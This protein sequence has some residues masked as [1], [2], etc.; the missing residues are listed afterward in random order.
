M[1]RK[2]RIPSKG[3]Q[4]TGHQLWYYGRFDSVSALYLTRHNKRGMK[5]PKQQL[6]Q[7]DPV[8][9]IFWW[10]LKFMFQ[11][12]EMDQIFRLP[13]RTREQRRG[14]GSVRDLKTAAT[15]KSF[16]TLHRIW[17]RFFYTILSIFCQVR[18]LHRKPVPLK[19]RQNFKRKFYWWLWRIRFQCGGNTATHFIFQLDVFLSWRAW[20]L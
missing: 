18:C 17:L 20:A 19:A 6:G 9:D 5:S 14:T 16:L 10:H 11:P 2:L 12:L 1:S 7:F 8:C 4:M 3:H 15:E 13:V